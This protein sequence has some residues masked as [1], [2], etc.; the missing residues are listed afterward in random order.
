MSDDWLI[1]I[2]GD[3]AWTPG[4][5]QSARA[6]AVFREM[7][8]AGTT[9]DVVTR[10]EVEF[11]D[12]GGNFERVSCPACADTLDGAWWRDAMDAAY[13]T[14]FADLAVTPPCC[15]VATTLND[16]VYSFPAGFSRFEL[17]AF[18]PQRE[19]LDAPELGRLSAALGHPVRQIF[20]HI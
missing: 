15:G 3:P 17:S 9:V 6:E 10:D 20:R 1:V 2:P 5:E 14:H 7:L 12:Q 8:P 13:E 16:L 11:V 19:W 18:R 4:P